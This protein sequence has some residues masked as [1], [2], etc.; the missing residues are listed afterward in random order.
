MRAVYMEYYLLWSRTPQNPVG[1]PQGYWTGF[2]FRAAGNGP[3]TII[4]TGGY[5]GGSHIKTLIYCVVPEPFIAAARAQV[6]AEQW[7]A[8]GD[9]RFPNGTTQRIFSSYAQ[10]PPPTPDEILAK[11]QLIALENM[12]LTPDPINA[13]TGEMFVLA[14]D[15]AVKGRGPVLELSRTY[16]S[17]T[18][19]SG[20]FGYGWRSAYDVNLT[21]DTNGN[22][23]I[24][25]KDGVGRYFEPDTGGGYT[26][27][28]GNHDTLVKNPD[29]TFTVTDKHG[30]VANYN[31]D[32]R[33]STMADRNG[34]TLTFVFDPAGDTYI[35]DAGGRRI[36]LTIDSNGR[37]QSARDPAGHVVQYT[38]DG[39]GNLT[40]ITDA[41]GNI[42]RYLYDANHNITEMTNVN[43]HKTYF[44]YDSEDRAVMNWQ[45]G[46][47]NKVTLSFDSDT[48]T[49]VTDAL[50]HATVYGLN[51]YGLATSVTDPLGN[52]TTTAWDDNL[53]R[54][55]TTDA[56]GNTTS[57]EYD[58][59]GNLIKMT[60][61]LG[62]ETGFS[63]TQGFSLLD[64]VADALGNI[65]NYAYDVKGNLLSLTDGLGH[66]TQM[67]YDTHGNMTSTTDALGHTGLFEYDVF[68]QL[69]KTTDPLSSAT[70]LACDAVGNNVAVTDP[71]GARTEFVYDALNRLTAVHFNDGTNVSYAY[72][73]FGNRLSI[74]DQKSNTTADAYDAYERP[75]RTTDASGGTTQYAYDKAGN[76]T[77]L[78]D[79][80]G[81][82]T[83]YAYDAAAR[84]L[85]ETT[86]LGHTTTYGYDAVGNLVSKTDANGHTITYTYDA[87]NRLTRTQYPDGTSVVYSYDALG[88][89]VSM[90]DWRGMTLYSYDALGRLLKIEGPES[91]ER[92]SYAYDALGN[93]ATM[94]NQDGETVSYG[95]DALNR[96]TAVTDG[97]GTTAY[98]YDA[99]SNI[100]RISYPN[101]AS[102]NYSYD[103][104]NRPSLVVNKDARNKKAGVFGYVY[105][106]AGMVTKIMQGGGVFVEYRY[107]A[108]NRLAREKKK[109][110]T[111]KQE[112]KI[113]HDHQYTYD[114]VGNRVELIKHKGEEDGKQIKEYSYDAGN[115][116]ISLT[117]D[118]EKDGLPVLVET[119]HYSYD[120]NGNRMSK[121]ETKLGDDEQETE[122]TYYGYDHENRLTNLEYIG[123]PD[124][125]DIPGALFEYDGSGI[126][127][128]AVEGDVITRYYYDGLNVLFEK[129]AAGLTQKS[130]TRGLGFPGG[131]GGLISMKRYEM[132]DGELQEKVHYY[133]YD[134]LGSVVNL[135]DHKGSL[136]TDY[137]YDAFGNSKHGKKWNTYRFSSKEFEDHAGLYYFGARYYDPEISR[138]LTADPLKFVDG[139]NMY[140]YVHNNPVNF[141]DPLGL[142][143]YIVLELGHEMIVIDDPENPGGL[144]IFD[145]YPNGEKIFDGITKPVVG[146]VR[147]QKLAPG[148]NLFFEYWAFEI[149]GTR[150]KQ[151][152]DEDKMMIERARQ[153]KNAAA[154]GDLRYRLFFTNL[155][156]IGFCVAVQSAGKERK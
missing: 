149:P 71:K 2:V 155:N 141:V 31:Q 83:N 82:T 28:P 72:D 100:T 56:R 41:A 98:S 37:V 8:F 40:T 45:D 3:A 46:D 6:L 138:W 19:F 57:F 52:T 136:T 117:R 67:A 14:E 49:T 95:Y 24:F 59:K 43:G 146:T 151:S 74:T 23:I 154:T 33:M 85:S 1:D 42:T 70:L 15:F 4:A 55:A 17:Q 51:G 69:V 60:D 110:E 142:D 150:K 62:H 139:F 38:Y 107:D 64:S 126:R 5:S 76:T 153:L 32:E 89:Q 113:R 21:E 116:L 144:L 65:T 94:T 145:F 80:N 84:L 9:F 133:H 20:L 106:P 61:A 16:R 27:S 54:T 78:T 101:G 147:E 137:E 77:A 90:T 104:M 18:E 109:Q 129:D 103:V 30:T 114:A 87:L 156:C 131:I 127:R 47:V 125:D 152:I 29:G 128:K 93:R 79:A 63:Y 120:N 68:G 124:E 96:L 88:R 122:I 75:S 44:A 34:N 11:P 97:Q 135:S 53:N 25:D 58:S 102:I 7:R 92:I 36:T 134:A 105:D 10:L 123:D 111:K 86:P 48:Q 39:N 22:V 132:D 112:V 26:A 91:N 66:T 130:Y 13:A 118:K 148:E 50:G 140:T 121:K 12:N 108:L 99:L 143:S 81:H 35:E 73:A 115:R 119:V